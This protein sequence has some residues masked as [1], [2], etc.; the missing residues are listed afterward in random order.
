MLEK[1]TKIQS[2]FFC[3]T[4]YFPYNKRLLRPKISGYNGG[5]LNFCEPIGQAIFSWWDENKATERKR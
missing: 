2:V 1:V 3:A 5:E 4:K